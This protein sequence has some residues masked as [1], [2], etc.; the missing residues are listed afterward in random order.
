M[1]DNSI[2]G[3][4]RAQNGFALQRN[5]ALFILLDNYTSKFKDEK[6]FICLEHHDDFLFCFLN[7]N[8][9]V[10][11]VEAYQSKKNSSTNWSLNKDF[12]EI[13]TKL[14]DTGNR[15]LNDPID[16]TDDYF[17]HLHFSSN[18]T[19]KLESDC[20][21][22][23][24]ATVS[25]ENCL[26]SFNALDNEIKEK[27]K[28]KLKNLNSSELNSDFLEDELENLSFLYIVFTRTDKEQRNQLVGKIEEVFSKDINDPRAA[29]DTLISLFNKI[30]TAYNQG[31]IAKLLDESKRVSSD[32]IEE[33]FNI[34][35]T[36]SKAFDY[37]RGECEEIAKILQIKPVEW[38]SFEFTFKSSFDLFKS[39]KESE[40][41]KILKFVKD[42]IKNCITYTQKD[43]INELYLNYLET[44]ESL[45]SKIDLKAIIYS[46]YFETKLNRQNL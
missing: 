21:P 40:H 10:C 30:E 16:R 29:V 13:L 20:K 35:T 2:N 14:L 33:T 43:N 36:Q 38:D 25:E 41:C 27:I 3:G 44:N 4:V 32:K 34:L 24:S 42:N 45:F 26:V 22:K 5:S 39:I 15:L 17:H 8:Y 31:S 19:I 12:I 37:W 28:T 7:D 9:K 46:A 23:I 18:T 6:Y 11:S 1:I